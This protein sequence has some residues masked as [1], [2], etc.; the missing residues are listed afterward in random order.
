MKILFVGDVVAE[1]GRKALLKNLPFVLKKSKCDFVIVNVENIAY[2]HGINRNT[3]EFLCKLPI[4]C[5]TLGN[6]YRDNIEILD[7]LSNDNIIRPLNIR[8]VFPGKGSNVYLC[9]GKKI[10]VTNLLGLS[11]MKEKVDEPY[12]V[13]NKL[14]ESDDSDIHIVDYHGESTGEKKAFSYLLSNK[15]SAVI[16]THTH[17]QTA[18][19][20]ILNDKTAYISDVGMC[21]SYNSVLGN[22]VNSVIKKT[23]MHDRTAIFEYLENDDML[24]NAVIIEFDDITNKATKIERINLL[25][26][27]ENG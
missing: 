15:L 8:R 22:E 25:N 2:G 10:R 18:D 13:M 7:V 12:Q 27:K 9:K 17:V 19:N 23:I 26:G 21:G 24:F 3:Y 1:V 4:N 16:G 6:H 5:M 11:F 14:I 20:Q